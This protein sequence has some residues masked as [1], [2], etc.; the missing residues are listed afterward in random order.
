MHSVPFHPVLSLSGGLTVLRA[1]AKHRRCCADRHPIQCILPPHILKNIARK[2]TANQAEGALRTLIVSSQFRGRRN[3]IGAFVAAAPTGGKRRTIYD[4]NNTENL[5]GARVRG[6]GD[7]PSGDPAVDEAY[8]GS[9]DT[10][11]FYKQLFNRNSIDDHGMR[12]DSTAHYGQLYDNAFW[13]GTQMVYGDGDK[14]LFNRFTIA[15]DVIGH[16]LTHGVTEHTAALEYQDQSGALNESMSDCFGI[17]IKQWK[18][19]QAATDDREIWIIGEKLLASGVNGDGLR[20][21]L[22]PG[23]AYDDPTLGKD[24]QP[25]NM[26]SYFRGSEDNGGVHINSGITNRAFALAAVAMG[27]NSWETVGPVWYKALTERLSPKS[28]FTDAAKATTVIAT[29]ISTALG[30]AVS[31][32]WKQVG[33][34]GGSGGGSKKSKKKRK[35]KQPV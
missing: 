32:A 5:P 13:N 10:Y 4:A 12:L 17:M 35:K 29:E 25:D 34:T 3:V 26:S 16:E 14:S 1:G 22:F 6:E 20:N 24:P 23:T 28:D 7:P 19:G 8:D 9:G 21:M 31:A 33:V 11:D 27:G 30:N 18:N 15:L 2:G